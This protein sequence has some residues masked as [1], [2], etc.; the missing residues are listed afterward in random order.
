MS[1]AERERW[2]LGSERWPSLQ[3]LVSEQ[4]A[5]TLLGDVGELA[6]HLNALVP[7]LSL[8]ERRSILREILDFRESFRER[9]D[10]CSFLRD[11][12]GSSGRSPGDDRGR[13]QNGLARLKLVYDAVVQ[14]VPPELRS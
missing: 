9:Y 13:G 7:T 14:S 4:L 10:D 11:G 1:R 5:D 12:F 8:D 3:S 6:I 2:Q